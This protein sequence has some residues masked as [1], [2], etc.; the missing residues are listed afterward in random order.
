M[1]RKCY[2]CQVSRTNKTRFDPKAH[3]V[4]TICRGR[5]SELAQRESEFAYRKKTVFIT[6]VRPRKPKKA[7]RKV[8]LSTGYEVDLA[9][10]EGL[11]HLFHA[12]IGEV[13]TRLK[14][15][16]EFATEGWELIHTICIYELHFVAGQLRHM[17]S[18]LNMAKLLDEFGVEWDRVADRL[19]RD[20]AGQ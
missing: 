20:R 4:C 7:D 15:T 16:E 6:T 2:L 14:D 18:G 8:T 10:E 9:D 17:G 11:V 5:L 1:K 12:I 3:C 13:T 19:N